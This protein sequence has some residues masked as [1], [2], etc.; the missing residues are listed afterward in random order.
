[1]DI[2]PAINL[3]MILIEWLSSG[4]D[5]LV[6][7]GRIHALFAREKIGEKTIFETIEEKLS[8]RAD[9]IHEQ[10]MYH[11]LS[12]RTS[13]QVVDFG[14]GDGQVSQRLYKAGLAVTGY[15]VRD[16][17][18]PG[19]TVPFKLFDGVRTDSPNS[20]F[21]IG[22]MTNVAHH[23]ADNQKVI[24]EVTRIIRPGGTLIMIETVPTKDTREEFEVT[25]MN[26]YLYNRL[27]HRADVPVP[28]TY[29]TTM[30][31]VLRFEDAGWSVKTVQDL[32]YDQPTIPDYHVLFVMQK[33]I[34]K[35]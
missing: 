20:Q 5:L 6:T 21:T 18:K 35:Q 32:G 23:A 25:F 22:V 2:K 33:S 4:D 7:E 11:L 30:N 10:I 34:P 31:W 29:E 3:A 16:Y 9:L 1:M 26:D 15:D 19:V 17:R 13:G 28:G 12:L 14:C 27:F 8:G 24:D